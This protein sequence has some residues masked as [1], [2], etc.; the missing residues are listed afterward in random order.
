MGVYVFEERVAMEERVLRKGSW[1]VLGVVMRLF[2]IIH[3]FII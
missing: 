2:Y 3:L 1:G